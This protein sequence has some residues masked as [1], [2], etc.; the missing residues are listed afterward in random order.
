M[1]G[2]MTA[3]PAEVMPTEM[4]GAPQDLDGTMEASLAEIDRDLHDIFLE[5]TSGGAENKKK[6]KIYDRH[7]RNYLEFWEKDQ[8][9]REEIAKQD[10]RTYVRVPAEPVTASKAALFFDYE[11]KRPRV[12]LNYLFM[13]VPL[14]YSMK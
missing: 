1:D 11:S 12:C 8:T 7:V 9:R 2:K 10:G 14:I 5:K 4:Q 6:K 13:F 3:A